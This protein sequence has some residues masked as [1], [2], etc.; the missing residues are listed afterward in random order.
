MPRPT[1]TGMARRQDPDACPVGTGGLLGKRQHDRGNHAAAG[2]KQTHARVGGDKRDDQ[3]QPTEA[4]GNDAALAEI[5]SQN[6]TVAFSRGLLGHPLHHQIDAKHAAEGKEGRKRVAV[7][8]AAQRRAEIFPFRNAED[9]IAKLHEEQQPDDGVDDDG[10]VNEI[11]EGAGALRVAG[12]LQHQ[13]EKQAIARPARERE[14]RIVRREA[15]RINGD[16][17]AWIRNA[18]H[19]R[20]QSA[21]REHLD[22]HIGAEKGE[23][24]EQYRQIPRRDPEPCVGQCHAAKENSAAQRDQHG[25]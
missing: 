6:R 11:D 8:E 14:D 18:G 7:D 20:R 3:D 21:E 5:S 22:N 10:P 19:S 9:R 16:D 2:G 1:T 13:E 23:K 17:G 12:D 25:P 24:T 15:D 4:D